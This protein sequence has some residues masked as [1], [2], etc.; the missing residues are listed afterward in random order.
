MSQ[1]HCEVGYCRHNLTH[2]TLG[3]ICGRCGVKGHG[4]Y[5]CTHYLSER[6]KVNLKK[7]FNDVMPDDKQCTIADCKDKKY[8][9]KEAHH[10]S[11][12][13]K[14]EQHTIEQCSK[15]EQTYNVKCPECRTEHNN[16]K[17]QKI[18]ITSECK[19]CLDNNI[20]VS[21]PC[22]HCYCMGCFKNVAQ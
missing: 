22:G 15:V 1:K 13:G 8:H 19:I 16:I 11:H 7:Y 10:C 2:T 3:H 21:L 14:R 6:L 17:I 9:S 18:F 5:E 4:D 20:D 12:C